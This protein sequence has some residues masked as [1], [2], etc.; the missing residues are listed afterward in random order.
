MSDDHKNSNIS[1]VGFEHPNQ[2][3][4][5]ENLSDKILEEA[6]QEIENKKPISEQPNLDQKLSEKKQDLEDATDDAPQET[7]Q[8]AKPTTE[9]IEKTD[10][11]TKASDANGNNIS[12]DQDDS[13]APEDPVDK[14]NAKDVAKKI[15]E[16]AMGEVE[17][18]EKNISEVGDF[19]DLAK[20]VKKNILDDPLNDKI[21]TEI[22]EEPFTNEP[23]DKEIVKKS[24]KKLIVFS[25]VVVIL[26]L[27]VLFSR[28]IF[29]SL[30]PVDD[31]KHV[32]FSKDRKTYL[33]DE[34]QAIQDYNRV[35]K[36]RNQNGERI[37]QN[38]YLNDNPNQTLLSYMNIA[39]ITDKDPM[40]AFYECIK[41]GGNYEECLKLIKDKR[42]LLQM[43]KTLEAYKDCIK[44]AKTEE[45]RIKCLELIKDERLKNSLKSQQ[46][47][48]AALDCIKNAKTEAEKK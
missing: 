15:Q 38:I 21:H 2:N 3:K 30:F 41:N 42:I 39:D 4:P 8:E 48:Q 14:P 1:S 10:Q 7:N 29:H 5:N 22:P 19:S 33:N 46:K 43:K 37:D 9:Q 24:N 12:K 45:D 11:D 25:V 27:L 6:N 28:T 23:D 20:E 16:D 18:F 34:V 35:I 13:L 31:K 36:N 40:N 26:V 44:N 47:V 17:G 32:R